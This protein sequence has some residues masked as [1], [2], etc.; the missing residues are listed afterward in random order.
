M[1]FA[2]LVLAY[3]AIGLL[4]AIAF[5]AFWAPQMLAGHPD[6]SV[7]ARLLLL[8]GATL[9]WPLVVHRWATTREHAA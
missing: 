8:P 4:V 3:V 7:G 6:I 1:Y 5:S 2:Y 9:L